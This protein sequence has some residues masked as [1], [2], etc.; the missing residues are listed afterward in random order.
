MLW[1]PPSAAQQ[2]AQ[3][4][5]APAPAPAST[6]GAHAELPD[7]LLHLL[8]GLEQPVHVR[9]LRAAPGRDPP[10]A[11]AVDDLRAGPL[12]PGHRQDDRLHPAHLA[13][14]VRVRELAL[15][16]A[17]A[18]QHLD[19][20]GDGAHAAELPDLDQEVVE[21]EVAGADAAL[22]LLRLLAVDR[23][24]GLLDQ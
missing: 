12:P 9:D 15:E 2:A 10:S 11:R 5:H 19:H 20:A 13:L 23:P 3:S 14:R 16:L 21:R 17:G 8:T 7:E 24:L 18:G 6:R 1:F 22:D 4:T